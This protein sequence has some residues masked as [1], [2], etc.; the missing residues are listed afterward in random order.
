MPDL[1]NEGKRHRLQHGAISWQIST[2]VKI[3]WHIFALHHFRDINIKKIVDLENV[4][5]GHGVK[6]SQQSYSMQNINLY[7]SHIWA[8]LLTLTVSEIFTFQI[9]TLKNVG[10]G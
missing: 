7:K 8:F 6:H 1:E 2:S 4:G 5:H 9:V 3:I 10:E